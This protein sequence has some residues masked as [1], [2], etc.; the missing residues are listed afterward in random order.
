MRRNRQGRGS[1]QQSL[2]LGEVVVTYFG[3]LL[4]RKF[5]LIAHESLVSNE[6][7]VQL[8]VEHFLRCLA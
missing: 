8:C 1:L 4:G 6:G 3:N 2:P 5:S 7:I